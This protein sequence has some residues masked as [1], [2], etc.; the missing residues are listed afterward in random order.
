[1]IKGFLQDIRIFA[2]ASSCRIVGA[3]HAD[4]IKPFAGIKSECCVV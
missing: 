2:F 4:L 3:A 1:M